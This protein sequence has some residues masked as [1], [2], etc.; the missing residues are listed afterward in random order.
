LQG[1]LLLETAKG[2]SIALQER[3]FHAVLSQMMPSCVFSGVLYQQSK[4]A[5]LGD[6]VG[7]LQSPS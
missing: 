5:S 3:P 7:V 6:S 1:T 4:L 2:R